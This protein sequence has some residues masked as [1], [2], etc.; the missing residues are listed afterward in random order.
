[1]PQLLLLAG[2]YAWFWFTLGGL[3]LFGDDR[4]LLP[5][6]DELPGP[7]DEHRTKVFD[8]FGS[9][10]AGKRIEEA[11]LPLGPVYLWTLVSRLTGTVLILCCF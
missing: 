1:M 7:D 8:I 9:E 3:A 10:G 2:M 6:S 11:A 4:P 5:R